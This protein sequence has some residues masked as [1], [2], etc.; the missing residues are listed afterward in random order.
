MGNVQGL[1]G[2]VQPLHDVGGVD[3]AVVGW[4]QELEYRMG[5]KWS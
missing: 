2:V 3:G 4:R 1:H 5:R